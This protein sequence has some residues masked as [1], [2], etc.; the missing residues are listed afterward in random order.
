MKKPID[1]VLLVDDDKATNFFHSIMIEESGITD[2]IITC[3]NALE[4]EEK[5]KFYLPSIDIEPII[6][7]LDINMPLMNGWMLLDSISNL[8]KKLLKKLNIVMV[9]ASEYP[10]DI[11]RINNHPLVNAHMP[12]TLESEKIKQYVEK[13]LKTK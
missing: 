7:F 12:K 11:E 5:I 1:I 13:M 10:K 9:S 2:N 4:A 6:L 3:N 8:D